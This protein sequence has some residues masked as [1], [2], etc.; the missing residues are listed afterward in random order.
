MIFGLFK[1]KRKRS[2]PDA[3][4]TDL[5][6]NALLNAATLQQSDDVFQTLA[7]KAAV[8]MYERAFASATVKG[9]EVITP[10]IMAA[11]G[12]DLALRGE[13]LFYRNPTGLH[14]IAFYDIY[15]GFSKH[16]HSYRIDLAGPSGTTTKNNLNY[17]KVWHCI[18]ASL[19]SKPYEAIPPLLGALGSEMLTSLENSMA[20]E[21]ATATGFTYPLPPVGNEGDDNDFEAM[22]QS[23][24]GAQ[25]RL[26]VTESTAGNWG[27]D[28]RPPMHDHKSHRY[29]PM[30]PET[31]L[32]VKES[33]GRDI[34]AALGIPYSLLSEQ[35]PAVKEGGRIWVNTILRGYA[36]Q[37][38]SSF[39]FSFNEEI[40][41][42]FKNLLSNDRAMGARGF[43][44]LAQNGIPKEE[45]LILSG[46]MEED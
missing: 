14:R 20:C 40:K 8:T 36:R 46:L 28:G 27:D 33:V 45:A 39:K 42:S 32:K 18:F 22:K 31:L 7:A 6:T 13:A 26:V 30:L 16:D 10:E 19:P 5:A 37:I 3:S 15:G 24:A 25:G 38:E 21:S 11:I 2:T 23:L 43:A 35:G 41:I 12:R 17:K 9:S 34:F 29:G 4:V 1:K 44:S